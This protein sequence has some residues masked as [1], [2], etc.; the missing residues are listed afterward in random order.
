[1]NIRNLKVFQT[2]IRIPIVNVFT[3]EYKEETN[4]YNFSR[5]NI[6]QMKFK[7]NNYDVEE[8]IKILREKRGVN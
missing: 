2:I 4:Y 5:N 8:K 3:K 6:D 1:M 7:S